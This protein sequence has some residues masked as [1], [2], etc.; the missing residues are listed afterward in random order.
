[1]RTFIGM[2]ATDR[3]GEARFNNQAAF[4]S[5]LN[6]T[7]GTNASVNNAN[8]QNLLATTQKQSNAISNQELARQ[9]TIRMANL[10]RMDQVDTYNT[11]QQNARFG[12][13]QSNTVMQL[14]EAMKNNNFL[15]QSLIAQ[16]E[17][18]DLKDIS[19]LNTRLIAA[20]YVSGVAARSAPA[21]E[22]LETAGYTKEQIKAMD[23]ASKERY[24]E[25]YI[26]KTFGN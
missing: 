17:Q 19:Q 3:S 24:K 20:K 2:D 7:R 15:A 9:D 4:T 5:A 22:V 21:A 8:I 13:R 23:D 10:G 16:K 6:A 11:A 25:M 12:D 14:G 18:A 1:M 26:S